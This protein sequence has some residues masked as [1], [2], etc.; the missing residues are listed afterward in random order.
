MYIEFPSQLT[1]ASRNLLM[2][3]QPLTLANHSKLLS[4]KT[5]TR[6]T[7]KQNDAK[8]TPNLSDPKSCPPNLRIKGVK[9]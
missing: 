5:P 9:Q 2:L 6:Y 1:S 8:T 4:Q 3:E 7:K